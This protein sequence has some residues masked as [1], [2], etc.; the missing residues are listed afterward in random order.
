MNLKEELEEYYNERRADYGDEEVD[1]VLDILKEYD[2]NLTGLGNWDKTLLQRL[3][4][5]TELYEKVDNVGNT[6]TDNDK[7]LFD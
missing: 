5:D 3:I 6:E 7:N 2:D 4:D 1:N